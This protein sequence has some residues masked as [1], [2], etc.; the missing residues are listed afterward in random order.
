MYSKEIQFIYLY[1]QGFPDGSTVKNP[2]ANAGDVGLILGWEDS[3]ENEMV[4]HSSILAWKISRT[5]G[6]G[7]LYSP[8]GRKESDLVIKQQQHRI[9]T[10]I[11]I[12]FQNL[13]PYR[14]SKILNVVLCGSLLVI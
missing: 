8:W 5:E 6:H 11:Y 10:H 3:W 9:C 2:P 7:R 14:L 1:I 12:L 4:T 13:F